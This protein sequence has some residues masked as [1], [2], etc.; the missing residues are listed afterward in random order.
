MLLMPV[1]SR[2]MLLQLKLMLSGQAKPKLR[3]LAALKSKRA[4]ESARVAG[5]A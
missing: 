3:A 2:L 1:L 4:A 5:L